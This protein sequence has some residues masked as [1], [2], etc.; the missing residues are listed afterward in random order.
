MNKARVGLILD[1]GLQL[2]NI[3]DLIKRSYKSDAYEIS[4]L[5]VHKS[6]KTKQ[7]SFL[8]L[9]Y[10]LREYYSEDLLKMIV[11]LKSILFILFK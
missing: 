2:W 7:K 5:I 1:N 8:R 11:F 10:L 3:H 9:F 6:Y 4:C